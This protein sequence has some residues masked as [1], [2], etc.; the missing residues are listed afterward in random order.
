MPISKD[1]APRLVK[2]CASSGIPLP[3]NGLL[4]VNV[5]LVLLIIHLHAAVESQ[6]VRD[7]NEYKQKY[8]D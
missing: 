1:V 6:I 5:K 3:G 8:A 7:R 4:Q 2:L